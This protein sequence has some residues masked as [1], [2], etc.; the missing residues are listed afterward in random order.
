MSDSSNFFI[1]ISITL[2]FQF[3]SPYCQNNRH[4]SSVRTIC[5]N[6]NAIFF[7][8]ASNNQFLS[9]PTGSDFTSSLI[10]P[11]ISLTLCFLIIRFTSGYKSILNLIVR[12]QL[13]HNLMQFILD[14]LVL[15]NLKFYV[16]LTLFQ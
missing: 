11:L 1:S 15:N 10:S 6:P 12:Y 4:N 14:I 16:F 2:S 5:V 13:S 7:K 9:S 8:D 3:I